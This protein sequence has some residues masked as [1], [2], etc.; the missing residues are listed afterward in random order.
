MET[1]GYNIHIVF[2]EPLKR[3]RLLVDPL[4][5]GERSLARGPVGVTDNDL[6]G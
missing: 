2:D 4:R 5:G 6:I 1:E 3:S